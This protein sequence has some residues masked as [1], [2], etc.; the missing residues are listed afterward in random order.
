M[1]RFWK[2][3]KNPDIQPKNENFWTTYEVPLNAQNCHFYP[4]FNACH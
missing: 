2:N 1:N 4:V 3:F